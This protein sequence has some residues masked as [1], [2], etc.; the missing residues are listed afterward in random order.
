MYYIC[1]NM[2]LMTIEPS[3]GELQTQTF[4]HSVK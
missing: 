1:L 2:Q 3:N 4:V